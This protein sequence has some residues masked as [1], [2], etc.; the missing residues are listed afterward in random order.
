MRRK[1][2]LAAVLALALC[3]LACTGSGSL[4][5]ET[6]TLAPAEKP[7]TNP[8]KGWAP[9]NG[10]QREDFDSTLAFVS[11]SWRELEPEQGVYAF[12]Q[13]ERAHQID[14]LRRQGVRL[15]LRVVCDYPGEEPHL[16]IP[17]WLYQE[18]GGP[19]NE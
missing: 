10:N 13:M 12:D 3:C 14:Q 9:W 7:V 11:V 18:T 19:W 4:Y 17:D 2:R 6:F 16:D 1:G 8:L 15:V 5:Q